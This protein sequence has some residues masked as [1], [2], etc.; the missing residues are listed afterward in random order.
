M[1][2]KPINLRR[3]RSSN[4]LGELFRSYAFDCDETEVGCYSCFDLA[5]SFEKIKD[6]GIL[7]DISE[8]LGLD[9][10]EHF[11]ASQDK[12]SG[13][14]VAW[15]WEGD[16]TLLFIYDEI[17]VCNTDCKKNYGWEALP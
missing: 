7:K 17:V 8:L 1:K 4:A 3:V 5:E 13:L 16:G 14:V 15:F 12:E 9:E 10:G 2:M 6:K 11:E